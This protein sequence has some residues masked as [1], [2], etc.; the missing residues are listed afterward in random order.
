VI[1]K[2]MI[3]V[4]PMVVCTRNLQQKAESVL[5]RETTPAVLEI[6]GHMCNVLPRSTKG[7][8]NGM[9]NWI[10]VHPRKGTIKLVSSN[11]A[12]ILE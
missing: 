6:W 11:Y 7:T 8:R 5:L 2:G 10:P 3:R 1:K 9:R 12:K 4:R